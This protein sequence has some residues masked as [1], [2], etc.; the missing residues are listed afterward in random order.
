MK[1]GFRTH[2]ADSIADYAQ[3]LGI[4]LQQVDKIPHE[5]PLSNVLWEAVL[6]KISGT[7]SH[8][9]PQQPDHRLP[10]VATA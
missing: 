2:V 4:Q 9:V 7:I 8:Y 5:K 10:T 6:A 1:L 3:N